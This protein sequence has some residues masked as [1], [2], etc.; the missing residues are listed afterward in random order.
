MSHTFSVGGGVEEDGEEE[1]HSRSF[2]FCLN[3]TKQDVNNIS[4]PILLPM[5]LILLIYIQGVFFNS[6]IF[7][8]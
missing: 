7:N 8:F 2:V 6:P 1:V 3:V 4:I 5:L